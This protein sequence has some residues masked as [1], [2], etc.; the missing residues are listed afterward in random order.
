[1]VGM[2]TCTDFI[3]RGSPHR[4]SNVQCFDVFITDCM[5]TPSAYPALMVTGL[6]NGK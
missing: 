1:M 6:V 2:L 4:P 5:V 3:L